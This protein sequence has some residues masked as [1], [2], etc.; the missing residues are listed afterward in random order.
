MARSS[1]EDACQYDL[2]AVWTAML[3]AGNKYWLSWLEAL[4]R[5]ALVG[6][7]KLASAEHESPGPGRRPLALAYSQ[8][9]QVRAELD[10][11]RDI[12]MSLVGDQHGAGTVEELVQA[13]RPAAARLF[14]GESHLLFVQSS[15]PELFKKL[16]GQGRWKKRYGKLVQASMPELV[17]AYLAAHMPVCLN[18]LDLLPPPTSNPTATAPQAGHGAV[19]PKVNGKYYRTGAGWST[20]V[21]IKSVQM[22]SKMSRDL[23]QVADARMGLTMVKKLAEAAMEQGASLAE[24]L[25]HAV[26][27]A[28]PQIQSPLVWKFSYDARE[29]HAKAAQTPFTY[30]L[31]EMLQHREELRLRVEATATL[32]GEVVKGWCEQMRARKKAEL[33]DAH[34]AGAKR[35]SL[36]KLVA[37]ELESRKEFTPI[38]GPSNEELS[39]EK[40]PS[41]PAQRRAADL[42]AA[43]LLN[44]H[45]EILEEHV[46]SVLNEWGFEENCGRLNV[47]PESMSFVYSDIL[48]AV[49][50]R[51][52]Q[53][54]LAQPTATY[55]SFLRL[56]C[57]YFEQQ[58]QGI[59]EKC[60]CP[61]PFTSICLNK[62]Y[63]SRKHRDSGN[64]G[65][66]GIMAL[67][68]FTTGG[69]LRYWSKDA[70]GA[71]EDLSEEAAMELDVRKL[72]I[73]DGN[74]A[75]C[76]TPYSSGLRYSLV[77]YTVKGFQLLR[78]HER[79]LGVHQVAS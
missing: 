27:E 22:E 64:E 37:Q 71:L 9:E 77:F 59:V 10:C 40:G 69:R 70:G 56:L 76:T 13:V 66:S 43:R 63:A 42:L 36:R 8:D 21:C 41:I 51:C 65:P 60:K 11:G 16:V 55:R 58:S 25:D 12:L 30:K 38:L 33:E 2:P 50:T 17:Q 18:R 75:H 34:A 6:L 74:K 61:M 79:S 7:L 28:R 44:D 1:Y 14:K 54:Q 26:R 24:A 62:G 35:A 46:L 5:A 52:G 23:A 31:E 67:G 47:M 20:K 49:R 72:T 48:G 45:V 73:F 57:K 32:T 3:E 15:L 29:L 53:V 4:P 68:S 19:A 78:G 39:D